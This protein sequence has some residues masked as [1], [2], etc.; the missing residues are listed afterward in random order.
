MIHRLAELGGRALDAG[1]AGA[2][3]ALGLVLLAITL[4]DVW[5][6]G[7]LICRAIWGP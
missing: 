2:D 3:Y 4:A 1:G 5:M 7:Y 6:G